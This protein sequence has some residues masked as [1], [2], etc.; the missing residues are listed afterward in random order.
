MAPDQKIIK[1]YVWYGD[2]CFYVSTIE[3]DSSSMLGPDRYNETIAWEYDWETSTRNE[4]IGMDGGPQ[5]SIT[6]HL[7]MCQRLHDTGVA[8]DNDSDT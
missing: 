5:G 7:Q 1:S 4:Q 3:R 2:K 8:D 6:A